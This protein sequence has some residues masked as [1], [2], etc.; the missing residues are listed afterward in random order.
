MAADTKTTHVD[1]CNMMDH[2]VPRLG[3]PPYMHLVETN[4]AVAS[5]CLAPFKCSTNYPGPPGLGATFNR[6]LWYMKGEAMGLEMRAFN[7]LQWHRATGD[8]PYSLIGVSAHRARTAGQGE[9][10]AGGW[11]VVRSACKTRARCVEQSAARFG[12]RSSLI[13]RA[14]ATHMR[15]FVPSS[16]SAPA[17]RLWAKPQHRPRPALRPDQRA[18]RYGCLGRR[19]VDAQ[20]KRTL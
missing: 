1:S 4:T 6:S 15:S 14:H 20:S 9:A 5:A 17:E 13:T 16:H 2:G 18:T 8:A 11:G 12:W 7:N 10:W 19:E 3:I